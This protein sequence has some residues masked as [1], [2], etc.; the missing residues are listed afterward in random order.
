MTACSVPGCDKPLYARGLCRAH[1]QIRWKNSHMLKAIV[2]SN[3]TCCKC[4]GRFPHLLPS[5]WIPTAHGIICPNCAKSVTDADTDE[6]FKLFWEIVRAELDIPP[7]E[8]LYTAAD[9]EDQDIRMGTWEDSSRP[10]PTPGEPAT[11]EFVIQP[12]GS[13]RTLFRIYEDEGYAP[14][15]TKRPDDLQTDETVEWLKDR[16]KE[17]MQNRVDRAILTGQPDEPT[18]V[19]GLDDVEDVDDSPVP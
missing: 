6:R 7:F 16:I 3:S 14:E 11:F 2:D 18:P 19:S 5:A 13:M 4:Q 8:Y 9:I 15:L 12:A 17:H 10:V 1:Y